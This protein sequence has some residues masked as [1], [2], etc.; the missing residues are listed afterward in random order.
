ME[1]TELVNLIAMVAG[2]ILSLAMAYVK[3]FRKW[4]EPKSSEEKVAWMGAFLFLASLS[5]FGL[6]CVDVWVTVA[7]T[8]DGAISLVSALLFSLIANQSTYT[9]A[10]RPF[11]AD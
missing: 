2:V 3:P 4:Y 5:I 9:Y 7:C 11:K 8:R 6:S 10:V 1:Q